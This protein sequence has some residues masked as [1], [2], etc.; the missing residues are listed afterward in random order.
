MIV[1]RPVQSKTDFEQLQYFTEV[2]SKN[3]KFSSFIETKSPKQFEDFV[4]SI[5]DLNFAFVKLIFR[6]IRSENIQ[7]TNVKSYKKQTYIQPSEVSEESI[8]PLDSFY[9]IININSSSYSKISIVINLYKEFVDFI[10]YLASSDSIDNAI[11]LTKKITRIFNSIN[12]S[13]LNT[14]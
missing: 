1:F 7:I 5:N 9:I 14:I 11:K 6:I 8:S 13:D 3:V 4:I 2:S 10:N 12:D